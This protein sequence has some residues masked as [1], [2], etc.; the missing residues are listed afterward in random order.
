[1]K[2]KDNNSGTNLEILTLGKLAPLGTKSSIPLAQRVTAQIQLSRESKDILLAQKTTDLT[3]K[4]A[5]E[6]IP[7]YFLI[8]INN[9]IEILVEHFKKQ[10]P[11]VEGHHGEEL[12]EILLKMFK[13]VNGIILKI[14]QKE[15]Y[16]E[17][18][19]HDS[20]KNIELAKLEI[21]LTGLLEQYLHLCL[22]VSDRYEVNDAVKIDVLSL[23]EIIGDEKL[24]IQIEAMI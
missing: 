22:K 13:R 20:G 8:V 9:E 6:E 3:L 14:R 7:K 24:D 23:R 10:I 4:E 16:R 11:K 5:G 2:T 21:L 18:F 15:T 19:L 1:M 17:I 12:P